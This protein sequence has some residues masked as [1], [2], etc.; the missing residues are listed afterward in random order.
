MSS[1]PDVCLKSNVGIADSLYNLRVIR[2]FCDRHLPQKT[3]HFSYE[4]LLYTHET[5]KIN[6][7]MMIAELFYWFEIKTLPIVTGAGLVPGHDSGQ[8]E[9]DPVKL[10][11]YADA[12]KVCMQELAYHL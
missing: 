5:V 10:L 8:G 7:M 12:V 11:F 2:S 6:L 9:T 1:I 3:W 4:D